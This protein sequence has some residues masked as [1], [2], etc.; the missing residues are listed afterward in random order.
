[1]TDEERI[2]ALQVQRKTLIRRLQDERRCNVAC[3]RHAKE[4]KKVIQS[5]HLCRTVQAIMHDY[6]VKLLNDILAGGKDDLRETLI[7]TRNQEIALW[8]MAEPETT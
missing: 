7:L 6:A 4:L 8:M 2:A 3:F 5:E 1:M